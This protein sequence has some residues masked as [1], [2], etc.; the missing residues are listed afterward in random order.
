MEQ[1]PASPLR[2]SLL[3]AV[4]RLDAARRLDPLSRHEKPL[5]GGGLLLGSSSIAGDYP[6]RRAS[7]RPFPGRMPEAVG[8]PAASSSLGGAEPTPAGR[9]ASPAHPRP[10]RG[11]RHRGGQRR[12]RSPHGEP[13][14]SATGRI[15]GRGGSDAA[16]DATASTRTSQVPGSTVWVTVPGCMA[17]ATDSGDARQRARAGAAGACRH[18]G[19][20]ARRR[21]MGGA[22][23]TRD[24]P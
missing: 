13:Y 10:A 23:R 24:T 1:R 9:H 4:L 14:S 5:R 12:A 20:G 3:R 6:P 21:A 22:S 11:G 18:N 7:A 19:A 15:A 16:L 17:V 2:P 8:V